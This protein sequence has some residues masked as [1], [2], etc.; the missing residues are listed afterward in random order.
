MSAP[1]FTQAIYLIGTATGQAIP[2]L[3]ATGLTF[4]VLQVG[5]TSAAKT[6]V[7]RIPGTS[8]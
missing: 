1:Y 6:V 4:G 2:T 5:R 7:L 8:P 3:S